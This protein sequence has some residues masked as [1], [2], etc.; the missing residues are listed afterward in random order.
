MKSAA[1]SAG[2]VAALLCPTSVVAGAGTCP[3]LAYG[4]KR[5]TCILEVDKTTVQDGGNDAGHEHLDAKL[6][7]PKNPVQI[8]TIVRTTNVY[9]YSF[10]WNY[11]IKDGCPKTEALLRPILPM[12]DQTQHTIHCRVE[13]RWSPDKHA[14]GNYS[15]DYAG[16]G[17]GLSAKYQRAEYNALSTLDVH[18]GHGNDFSHCWGQPEKDRQGRSGGSQGDDGHHDDGHGQDKNDGGLKEKALQIL[19][20]QQGQQSPPQSVVSV[21]KSHDKF[22]GHYNTHKLHSCWVF[23]KY[24]VDIRQETYQVTP[25]TGEKGKEGD[26]GKEADK[27]KQRRQFGGFGGFG[28]GKGGKGGK[29]GSSGGSGGSVGSSGG[30]GGGSG[31]FGGKGGNSGGGGGSS[32]GSGGS[33]GSFGGKV[34]KGIDGDD[35]YYGNWFDYYKGNA[36]NQGNQGSQGTQGGKDINGIMGIIGNQG[37]GF[38]KGKED[39]KG[40]EGNQGNQ[41]EN[42]QGQVG[43]HGQGGIHR[44]LPGFPFYPQA[45]STCQPEFLTLCLEDDDHHGHEQKKQV[46]DQKQAVDQKQEAAVEQKKEEDAGQKK[47]AESCEEESCSDQKSNEDGGEE[48]GH[49]ECEGEDCG[50]DKHEEEKHDECDC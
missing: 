41:G 45:W 10:I 37:T 27:G 11:F 22:G 6:L 1:L 47:E 43:G 34:N 16:L 21:K 38:D 17:T 26:K 50:D 5:V 44:P 20:H 40:K 48:G 32:G 13:A 31:G 29:G 39:D 2:L 25:A 15:V 46:V 24:H 8:T 7:D 35:G 18:S 30:I 23:E 36:G 9:A 4:S 49:D 33:G 12:L 42:G 19:Q 3:K 14:R 28:G